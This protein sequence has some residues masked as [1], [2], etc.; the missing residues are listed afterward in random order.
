M[1]LYNKLKCGKN[2][3]VHYNLKINVK[4]EISFP[5]GLKLNAFRGDSYGHKVLC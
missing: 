5:L 3:A 2:S 4:V 1:F